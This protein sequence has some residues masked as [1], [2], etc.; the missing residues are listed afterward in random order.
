MQNLR[1]LHFPKGQNLSF[2]A[3]EQL[4]PGQ[5]LCFSTCLREVLISMTAEPRETDF[6]Q[7]GSPQAAGIEFFAGEQAYQFLLEL[8]SGLKSEVIGETEVFGQFKSFLSLL[9]KQDTLAWYHFKA[10]ARA[11]VIDCKTLREKFLTNLGQQSYGSL[12]RRHL[13]EHDNVLVLGGGILTKDI[14]PW[15]QNPQHKYQRQIQVLIRSQAKLADLISQFPKTLFC[16]LK[17]KQSMESPYCLII[18]APVSNPDLRHWIKTW[19]K[20]ELVLDL[21]DLETEKLEI[22]LPWYCLKE[23]FAELKEQNLFLQKTVALAKAEIVQMT[24]V[25][26]ESVTLRPYGWEDVCA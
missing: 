18:A 5:W 13:G 17:Q 20:P 19:G 14:L 25:R 16:D 2:S 24:L 15:L 8:I 3:K 22:G 4:S 9:E 1:I 11:L 23:L 6:V 10:L 21:R 12:V 7:S 26:M